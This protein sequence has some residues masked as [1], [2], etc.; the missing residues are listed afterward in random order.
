LVVVLD[1]TGEED[2]ED[3]V[4]EVAILLVLAEGTTPMLPTCPKGPRLLTTFV[5]DV[6]KKVSGKLNLW[7]HLKVL[8]NRFIFKQVTSLTIARPMETKSL[9]SILA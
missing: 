7:Y 8:F 1:Q 5:F 9:I 3:A 4:E 2:V 6:V